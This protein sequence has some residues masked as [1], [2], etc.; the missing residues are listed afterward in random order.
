MAPFVHGGLGQGVGRGDGRED[1]PGIFCS[2]KIDQGD[3]PRATDF[4]KGCPESS[5]IGGDGVSLHPSHDEKLS[6]S[7]HSAERSNF[8]SRMG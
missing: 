6:S 7:A 8:Y 1:P 3:L 4:A 2:G 5:A